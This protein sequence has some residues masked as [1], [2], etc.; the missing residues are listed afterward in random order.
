MRAFTGSPGI[1]LAVA[2][3]RFE[4]VLGEQESSDI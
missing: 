2:E 3:S 1:S 4:G